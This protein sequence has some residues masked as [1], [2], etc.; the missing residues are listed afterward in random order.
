MTAC[1]VL[2]SP[3]SLFRCCTFHTTATTF[4]STGDIFAPENT[5]GAPE[6]E[7]HCQNHNDKNNQVFEHPCRSFQPPRLLQL[8]TNNMVFRSCQGQFETKQRPGE[9]TLPALSMTRLTILLRRGFPTYALGN[10]TWGSVNRNSPLSIHS[11]RR[12][13]ISRA[14]T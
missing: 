1:P 5:K 13:A 6:H 11:L 7:G 12:R 9:N 2:D 10:M 4:A 14:L 8:I 3:G